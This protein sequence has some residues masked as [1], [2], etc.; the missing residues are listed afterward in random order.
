MTNLVFIWE[1]QSILSMDPSKGMCPGPARPPH[2]ALLG[3][4]VLPPG[5]L[6]LKFLHLNFSCSLLLTWGFT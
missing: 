4:Q 5:L 3:M 6:S 2:V 1:P